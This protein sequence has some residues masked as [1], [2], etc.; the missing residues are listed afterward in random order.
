[1]FPVDVEAL[2]ARSLAADRRPPD[3]KLHPSGDLIGSLRHAQL[4]AAGAPTLPS[5]I[6]SDVRLMTGTLWHSYFERILAT[7]GVKVKTEVK[8]DRWLPEGWSGTADWIAWHPEHKAW[9]LGD[10]KTIKGEG[11]AWIARDGIKKEHM[12]Q[13]SAYWYALEKTG[14]PLLDEFGIFYLPMNGVAGTTV[15]P[16]FQVATPLDREIVLYTMEERWR[17]TKLYLDQVDSVRPENYDGRLA[18]N[19]I[20]KPENEHLIYL[21]KYLAPEQEREQVVRWMK[22]AKAGVEGVFE[23]K[24]APHWSAAYCPFPNE[25]CSCSEQGVTKIGHYDLDGNY[26]PRKGYENVVPLSRPD[27]AA[28][29]KRRKERDAA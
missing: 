11:M 15:E 26:H 24:L 22:G 8:L 1:M 20:R 17:L 23:V 2:L 7:A 3:G 19:Y 4:R 14:V 16:S 9:A 29:T 21:N 5:D 27:A 28:I 6:T 13:L 10:L 18:R 25:L 12:W